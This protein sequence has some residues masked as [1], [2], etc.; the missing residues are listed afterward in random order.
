MR[1]AAHALPKSSELEE[2][3]DFQMSAA[4][5]PAWETEFHFHPRRKWRADR[6][7]P[8]FRLLVEVEGGIWTGG[9]HVT[10]AG[11]EADC[12]KYN[13]AAILG[14]RVIRVTRGMIEDG[15]A[16][17]MIMRALGAS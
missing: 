13:E 9:R 2:Q 4:G 11:Y 8:V 1:T 10:G 17:D 7:W 6:A 12:I 16:L 5:L 3:L 15:R 14:Y